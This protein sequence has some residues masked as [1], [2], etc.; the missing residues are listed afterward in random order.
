[1]VELE[2]VRSSGLW[3]FGRVLAG[4]R[5]TGQIM[6]SLGRHAEELALIL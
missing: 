5:V 2:V 1:M 6:K 3:V 4:Q